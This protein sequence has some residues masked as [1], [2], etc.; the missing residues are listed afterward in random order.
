MAAAPFVITR[1]AQAAASQPGGNFDW[2]QQKGKQLVV[3]APLQSY[4][5]IVQKLIPDFMKLTGIEVDYQVVPEQQLRQKLPIE[6][7]AK[8]SAI[9]VYVTSMQVEKLLFSAAGWYEPL[10][11]Y[12]ENPGLTPPDYDW[13]D[14]GPAGT[15]WGLKS[16]GTVVAIPMGVGLWA[17]M[18][19]QDLYAEKGLNPTTTVDGLIAAVKALHKPPVMYGFVGRGLKNANTPLWG[20][21]TTA[22][23]GSCLDDSKTRLL[24]TS[25]EAIE[26]AKVY[27]D[28]MRTYGPPGSIGFNWMECQGA[29]TQGIVACWSD[30]LNFALP[31]E[32][33]TRSKVKGR[34]GYAPHPGSSR[35]KPFGGTSM[36]AM[37]INPFGKNKEAAWL[38]TAWV[39]SRPVMFNL[40]T[41]GAMIG[42]RNSIYQ[43]P[44][45][46]KANSLPK[47][48]VD[49][50]AEA[51]Q[52]PIPQLPELRDV[53]QFRDIYGIA[54]A[55]I[56]EGADA[57]TELEKATREFEPIF[58]KGLRM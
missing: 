43:D 15:Y 27:A 33:P 11:R 16:D 5:S 56:V 57:R 29:F 45:F 31:L 35:R 24:T 1:R 51:L 40:M 46:V 58:Q 18:Y 38:F 32:D 19:R 20:C 55:N 12:L 9:D 14:F 44:G 39:S 54:L 36:D 17:Y 2:M 23:G 49:A 26:A 48:W 22:L 4:Y 7:N 25:E 10:N 37:A 47:G 8:S 21:L 42:T 52:N 50:V 53:N 41:Q 28:L 13:K 30:G 34:V 6:M 3:A